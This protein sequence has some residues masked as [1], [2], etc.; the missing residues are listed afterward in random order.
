MRLAFFNQEYVPGGD[1]RTLL[2]RFG[3]VTLC[4]SRAARYCVLMA[5]VA[6][7]SALFARRPVAR[8]GRA[9]LLCRGSDSRVVPAQPGLHPSVCHPSAPADSAAPL[10]TLLRH[11]SSRLGRS[12]SDLKPE[13]FL[14]DH[15]GHVKLTDFG[16]AK[17]ALPEELLADLTRS[18]RLSP[19]LCLLR[20]KGLLTVFGCGGSV[21]THEFRSTRQT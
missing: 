12:Y 20:T 19:G 5:S 8:G 9:V 16:L 11:L 10:L 21:L 18:V 4:L 17:G 1:L 14:I 3:T 2:G 13:N 6:A 15:R 7:L